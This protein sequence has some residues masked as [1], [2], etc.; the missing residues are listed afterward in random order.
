M[1]PGNESKGE[2]E[3]GES[4]TGIFAENPAYNLDENL[5]EMIGQFLDANQQQLLDDAMGLIRLNS[6]GEPYQPASPDPFGAGCR[7]ALEE[8]VRLMK[9]AGLQVTGFDGYGVKGGLAG[10]DPSAGG[11]GFFAHLDVVPEG[12]GW[13]FPPYEPFV[14]D[15][16]LFGRGAMDNKAAATAALYVL[17]FFQEQRLPLRHDL[18]LFLGCNEENGM[19]DIRHFLAHHPAPLFGLVPDAYFP[20]CFAEK[21]MLRVDFV[22]APLDEGNL[23]AFSSGTEYNVVPASASAILCEAELQDVRQRLPESFT[24]EPVSEG[25]RITA[26]GKAGHAAF[27][28]GTEHAGV[29]LAAALLDHGLV[30]GSKPV[31]T[32]SFIRE[33][34]GSPY[35]HGLGISLDDVSGR[36]TCN[37]GAIHMDRSGLRLLCD[38]RYGV[39]QDKHFIIDN[40]HKISTK[41]GWELARTE[42]SPPHYIQPDDP[43]STALNELANQ[44]LGTSQP[45]YAMGGITH[46]RWLPR[47][48]AFGP[49][50]RDK[51]F[52]FPPG[53]GG[54]HQ[55]DEA[56]QLESIWNAFRIYVK[57][58]L[59]MDRILSEE[60]KPS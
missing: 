50:R 23:V 58:V 2:A 18:Y 3:Q 31:Q 12:E 22:G 36:T 21:G 33:C 29:K 6:V 60:R 59:V 14:R 37:A 51:I 24:V 34:F 27:P 53:K 16:Y 40:M 46:A 20:L 45:P 54:G 4:L 30:H 38:I 39:T 5:D 52:P 9:R 11:I 13:S 35:G 19:R 57:A 42:D 26:G 15:G 17:K 8:A 49:L 25:V 41:Y 44:E 7:A 10:R 48:A 47:A 28:E 56:M 43:I 1:K 55:P 32:L